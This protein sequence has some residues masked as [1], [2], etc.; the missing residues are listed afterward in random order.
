MPRAIRLPH[1]V[2]ALGLTL[3]LGGCGDSDSFDRDEAAQA[4][5]GVAAVESVRA[6]CGG[7]L[8]GTSGCLAKIALADNAPVEDILIT[9]DQTRS[10]FDPD[11]SDAAV[12]RVTDWLPAQ[13][14]RDP[15]L[16]INLDPGSRVEGQPLAAALDL[17]HDRDDL[18]QVTLDGRTTDIV[19]KDD[20]LAK[21][22][23]DLAS[24]F[25][26]L[27]LSDFV[28]LE[29]SAVT[30]YAPRGNVPHNQLALQASIAKKFGP[31]TA[32]LGPKGMTVVVPAQVDP[33][34][35]ETYARTLPDFDASGG[36]TVKTS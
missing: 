6:S 27:E 14:G 7:A 19:L 22:L 36:L 15:E 3:G 29:T 34:A 10:L 25:D 26:A 32:H 33:S 23:L 17:I 12:V 1:L 11:S 35:V 16:I 31:V 18:V 20:A 28:N 8:E 13:G 30:V 2:V 21:S 24:A 9:V 5:K 4:L